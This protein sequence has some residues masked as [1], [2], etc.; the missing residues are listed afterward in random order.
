MAQGSAL[1]RQ[2]LAAAIARAYKAADMTQVELAAR[3][4]EIVDDGTVNQGMVSRWSRGEVTP[5]LETI[6]AIEDVL[7][8]PR[9][10]LLT[11]SGYVANDTD[12]LNITEAIRRDPTISDDRREAVLYLYEQGRRQSSDFEA[13]MLER[14]PDEVRDAYRRSLSDE[15]RAEVRKIM[16]ERWGFTSPVE[17]EAEV[18]DLTAEVERRAG[19]GD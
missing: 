6:A 1:R 15:Q 3:L 13:L 14:M 9:G 18:V 4:N 16:M 17:R 11:E 5:E 7:S 12:V 10:K 19:N 8:L 2:S